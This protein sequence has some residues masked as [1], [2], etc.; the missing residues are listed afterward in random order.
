MVILLLGTGHVDNM[1]DNLGMSFAR[2]R[3]ALLPLGA[4]RRMT[5]RAQTLPR[6]TL[7]VDRASRQSACGIRDADSLHPCRAED[8]DAGR[9]ADQPRISREAS[10]M[11]VPGRRYFI[12]T[13]GWSIPSKSGQRVAGPGTHLQRYARVFRG[14]EINTTFYRPHNPA[15]YARWARSTGPSFR[16]AIKIPRTITHESKLRSTRVSLNRF[17]AESAGLGRKRGPLL[18]QLPPSLEFDRPTAGSFFRLLRD[19]FDG[20]AVC[21]PRHPTWFSPAADALLVRHAIGRVAADPSPAPGGHRPGGWPGV[22]YYRLHGSPRKYWSSY[23]A[24]FLDALADDVRQIPAIVPVWCVFD[25]TASGAAFENAWYL[26]GRL[27]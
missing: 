1:S 23:D 3:F 14:A 5:I 11:N 17:L 13:A 20:F 4:T 25:N 27:A 2:D 8:D 24:T 6:R 19:L 12:G 16:F 18:I 10:T 26:T 22:V 9:G 15:T 7:H 21:E